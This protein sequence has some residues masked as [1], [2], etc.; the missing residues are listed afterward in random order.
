MTA[1]V[2]NVI[3]KINKIRDNMKEP[4]SLKNT[5]GRKPRPKKTA[6]SVSFANNKQVRETYESLLNLLIVQITK[7][8]KRKK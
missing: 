2:G 3:G 5:R 4:H 1:I 7:N 8:L 6:K